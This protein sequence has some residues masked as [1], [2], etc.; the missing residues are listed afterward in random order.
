MRAFYFGTRIA[1]VGGSTNPEEAAMRASALALALTFAAMGVA[2]ADAKFGSSDEAKAMLKK[3]EAELK[4]DKAGTMEKMK[5]GDAGFKDRD[6]YPFCIGPDG[7]TTAH[8][9]KERIGEKATELKDKNGKLF[10]KEMVDVAKEGKVSEVT[11]YFPRPGEKDAV[12]KVS[13]VTKIG[14]QVCGVGYYK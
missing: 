12:Q 1:S 9:M 5:N 3:V 4:R 2:A 10:A 8:A 6:L 13:Y 11:Y 7:K 14:D